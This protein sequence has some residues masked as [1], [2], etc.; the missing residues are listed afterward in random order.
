MLYTKRGDIFRSF[1]L[2]F[3]GDPAEGAGAGGDLEPVRQV[4]EE[5][6]QN[7]F[8]FHPQYRVGRPG[9]PRVGDVGGAAGQDLGVGGLHVGVGA[10]HGGHPPVRFSLVASA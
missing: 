7:D 2:Q 3:Q 4:G 6:L 9:H 10:Q 1:A 5:P 8:L